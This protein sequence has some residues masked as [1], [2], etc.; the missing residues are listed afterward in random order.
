MRIR[1][2]PKLL[3]NYD[4]VCRVLKISDIREY[5]PKYIDEY[6]FYYLAINESRFFP[7]KYVIRNKL[8]GLIR[9][10]YNRSIGIKIS[11]ELLETFLSSPIDIRKFIEMVRHFKTTSNFNFY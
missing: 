8:E 10:S 2:K 4:D 5:K 9:K 7:L 1:L 11:E 3:I 6:Y